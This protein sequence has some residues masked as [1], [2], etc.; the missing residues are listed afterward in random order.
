MHRLRCADR[1]RGLR[2]RHVVREIDHGERGADALGG[3]VLEADHGIDRNV[4]LAAVD[5]VDN[6][7]VFLVDDAAADFSG[8][9]QFAVVRVEF[10]VEQQEFGDALRRR[11]R[12]VDRFDLLTHQ[13]VYFGAR[14]EV[15]VRRKR[16]AFLLLDQVAAA[17]ESACGRA[18]GRLEIRF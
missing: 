6:R 7:R 9:G 5:R 3:A 10:L 4:A 14:G 13:L 11:Q 17:A 1:K 15:S 16:N 12:G 2:D 18:R 8:A